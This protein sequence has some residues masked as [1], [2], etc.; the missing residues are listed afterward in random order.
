MKLMEI[1]RNKKAFFDYEILEMIEAGILLK[2]YETKSIRANK[3][4]LKGGYVTF[5]NE[6]AWLEQVDISP[7][8][9]KNQPEENTKKPRKL[10]LNKREI[11][12]LVGQSETPGLTVVPLKVILNHNRIKII[13]GLCRGKKQFDKR[14]TI[15]KRATDRELRRTVKM[16]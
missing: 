2:G 12:K 14:E 11:V 16:R 8:Q 5:R 6:E 4:N 10:L 13:I 3:I 1:T 15:K 7:Y 9:P